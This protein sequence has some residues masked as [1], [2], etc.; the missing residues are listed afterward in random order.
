MALIIPANPIVIKPV[1]D[2]VSDHEKFKDNGQWF[3][4]KARYITLN[5]YNTYSIPDSFSQFSSTAGVLNSAGSPI[6]GGAYRTFVDEVLDNYAYFVSNQ[7]NRIFNH[8]TTNTKNQ[9][10]PNV[11]IKGGEIGQ[12]CNHIIGK[13]LQV[14]KPIKNNISCDTISNNTLLKKQEVFD[15]IDI[16]A[17][18]GHMLKD[19]NIEFRPSETEGMD[20]SNPEQAK[21]K[22]RSRYQ[23]TGTIVARH[24]YYTTMM[25]QLFHE[26][27]RDAIIGG[28]A[29]VEFTEQNKK[30]T[31]TYIPSYQ[32]IY[33]FSVWGEFGEGQRLGGYIVPMTLEEVLDQYPNL[34][35]KATEEIKDVLYNAVDGANTFMEYYNQPFQNVKW[36]Y[37]NQKWISKATVYWIGECDLPYRKKVNS[38][39]SKSVQKIDA[40]KTYQ[41]QVGEENGKKKYEA[42]KGYELESSTRVYKV[43]KAVILGN[44]YLAEYG[45]DTYQVRPF[46]EKDKPVIPIQFFCLGKIAGQVKSIVSKLKPKQD[47]LDAVRYRIRMFTARDKGVVYFIRGGKLGEGI[48]TQSII[49][50]ISS[51]GLTVIPETGDEGSDRLGI[52]DLIKTEDMTNHSYIQQYLAL[53]SDIMN[54]MMAIVN[55][56][57]VAMGEQTDIIGKGVQEATIARAEI[58]SLPFFTSLNEFFRR[59]IQYAANKNK[60]ILMDN[61]DKNIIL[62]LSPSEVTLLEKTKEFLYEDLMVYIAPDDQMAVGELGLFKQMLH[63]YSQ[64]PSILHA[65]ALV[66]ALKMMQSKSFGE[67]IALFENYV[68]EKKKE[69]EQMQMR[70]QAIQQQQMGTQSQLEQIRES[71]QQMATLLTEL[72]KI[73]AKGAWDVKKMEVQQGLETKYQVDDAI[74]NQIAT[75]VQDQMKIL[76]PQQ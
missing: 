21:K 45:Y 24:A 7:N 13:C 69:A 39:G 73:Q 22:V 50:D 15:K 61:K 18:I 38:V 43:H 54:E 63:S 47:E 48:D 66:N 10:L 16:A 32:A 42:K 53:K 76:Q 58:S 67:G 56:P 29:G 28:L 46:G 44:K 65:E 34:D 37:N 17:S 51:M 5:Y 59:C 31:A 4:E 2:K 33:D 20:I 19:M 14:I 64:D 41:V 3:L 52:N 71:Q 55:I 74:I 25:E 8:L 68:E 36:W 30:L 35:P 57:P 6:W 27:S 75:R 11:W 12:L 72:S 40:Y 23:T 26:G 9:P 62:P 49:D 1:P 70:Q 60:M